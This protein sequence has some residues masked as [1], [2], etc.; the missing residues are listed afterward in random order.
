MKSKEILDRI[1]SLINSE[2]NKSDETKTESENNS[3]K[4]IIKNIIYLAL[5]FFLNILKTPFKI[6]DK[7]LYTAIIWLS[8]GNYSASLT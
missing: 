2:I 3:D 7:Y 6:I 1:E 4:G 5:Q 8:Q